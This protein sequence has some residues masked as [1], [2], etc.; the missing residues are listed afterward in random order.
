[1]R[2][3]GFSLIELMITLAIIALLATITI[4]L[5][6]VALQRQ[7][8]QELRLA[9]NEIR[10]ALDAYKKAVDDGRVVRS[11]NSSGYPKNLEMLV[12]GVT[13]A[14]DPKMGNI[15]FL[16]RIP[17]DPMFPDPD[18]K[19]ADTWGKRSYASDPD[20]PREGDDVY[21]VYS[22]SDQVGLNGAPYRKW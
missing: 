19:P 16:R 11:I 3:Q 7:K 17:K 13:D 12:Q 10:S 4:P 2:Q 22:L 15:Y 8:E 5:A 1:M 14:R 20:H 18:T 6:E 9:L 21:D